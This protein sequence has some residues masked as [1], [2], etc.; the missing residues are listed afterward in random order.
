MSENLNK[1]ALPEF[2]L[3]THAHHTTHKK[4]K[5]QSALLAPQNNPASAALQQQ[6]FEKGYAEG[7]QKAQ[8]EMQ[9]PM[10]RLQELI[11]NLQQETQVI[12]QEKEMAIYTFVKSLCE[13]VF[14]K[15]M[16]LSADAVMNVITQ[17]LK[18]IEESGKDMRI[19][20]HPKL[21]ATLQETKFNSHARVIVEVNHQLSDFEFRIE[22]E[23]QKI[24]FNTSQII[25]K[26]FDEY[27]ACNS[28]P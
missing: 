16:T 10:Q 7:L 20:C 13:K 18:M 21:Y 22:S 25:N 14:H 9:Q 27:L 23:K 12:V 15:E 4:L 5:I 8:L 19:L 26:L 11:N 6:G 1:W 17:A 28:Q 2:G 3:G 24:C